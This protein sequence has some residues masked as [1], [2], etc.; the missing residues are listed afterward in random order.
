MFDVVNLEIKHKSLKEVAV[1]KLE[2][3]LY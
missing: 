2:I 3:S 1:L